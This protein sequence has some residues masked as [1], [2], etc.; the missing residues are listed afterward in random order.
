MR[1]IDSIY[2]HEQ[3]L[4]YSCGPASIKMA[5]SC[6]G[7]IIP[8]SRICRISK[9]TKD[10]LSH[11]QMLDAVRKLGFYS[12]V[13]VDS[14]IGHLKALSGTGLPVIVNYNH[15]PRRFPSSGEGGHYAVVTRVTDFHVILAD[16]VEG[17]AHKLPIGEFDKNWFDRE[18]VN[19]RWM[20]AVCDSKIR[21]AIKGRRSNPR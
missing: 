5:L 8:E 15:Q 17:R 6:F 2:W 4:D 7:V 19:Q 10:G 21:V 9:L 11:Q 18:E 12:F 14:S 1:P 3:E 16:P 20:M 13:K